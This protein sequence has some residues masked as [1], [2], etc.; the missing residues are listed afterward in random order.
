MSTPQTTRESLIAEFT[1]LVEG[2]PEVDRHDLFAR[3]RRHVPIFHSSRLDAWVMTR[4]EDVKTVLSNDSL[5]QPPQQGA[6][7]SPFGRSFMQMSGREHSKKVGIVAREMR[8]QRA[9]RERLSEVVL[10]IAKSQATSLVMGEPMDLR[11]RYATWVPLLAITALTDLPDAARFRDW[12]RTIVAGGSSSITNPGARDAAFRAREEVRA[13]LE[14]IIEARRLKPGNDLLSDL[15]TADYDGEPIPHEEIVSNIIFLLAAG[16]ET[17]ERVLTS[18][19]RHVALDAEEWAWLKAN[20]TD[21]EA[22]SAFC[23]EA[24]RVFPPVSA[25]VRTALQDLEIAGIKIKAGEKAVALSVSGNHD[26]NHFA[27]PTHFDHNRFMGSSERQFTA[28]GDILSF[29]DG[30]HHC[31][32]SR[33]AK[34]EMAHALTEFLD[35]VARIEPV[36]NLPVGEGFIFHSPP[37]L[38][39]ILHPEE[40]I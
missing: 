32:G 11:E 21:P 40:L 9:M 30:T 35:R 37:R 18:V 29:G 25:N 34:V 38:P 1:A 13:F 10:Q 19:L 28:D 24:L 5:F 23:A 20:Y 31:V 36:G 3:L 15:V 4:Y 7:A 17:T 33:L 16:V 12:Y 27:N 26:E 39:V 8:T 6:G 2:S 22:L 14:P